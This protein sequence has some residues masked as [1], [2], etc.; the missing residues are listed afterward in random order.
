ML[1]HYRASNSWPILIDGR[2]C[3]LSG[4]CVLDVFLSPSKGAGCCRLA[5]SC[6]L[7]VLPVASVLIQA[8][9]VYFVRVQNAG[10]FCSCDQMPWKWSHLF[11]HLW[12][13]IVPNKLVFLHLMLG[14]F[15]TVESFSLMKSVVRIEHV[16]VHVNVPGE[17]LRK[18][19]LF[20]G[21]WLW[22]SIAQAH[23]YHSANP[24]LPHT[25]HGV[26]FF[27]NS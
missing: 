10:V 11:P 12:T 27:M 20:V 17:V 23:L 19:C 9:H 25:V 2:V 13:F 3:F 14:V 22:I 8:S 16:L 24:L 26:C 15:V 1:L 6:C 21:R 7:L 4:K 5:P 18:S